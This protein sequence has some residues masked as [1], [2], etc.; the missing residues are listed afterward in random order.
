MSIKRIKIKNVRGIP[1]SSLEINEMLSPNKPIFF[2]APNGFGKTS[3]ATAF[4]SLKTNKLDVPEE[5]KHNNDLN[6]ESV[7]E[8][9]DE[10]KTYVANEKL[11]NINNK[12]KI[13]VINTQVKPK[14][15]TH[16]YG[17][18]PTSTSSLVVEPI[19]LYNVIP[20][21]KKVSYAFSEIK[22]GFN[23]SSSKLVENL[24]QNFKEVKFIN[25]FLGLKKDF[26]KL[27][28]S[29]NSQ[30]L[31]NFIDK[32]NNISDIKEE[33]SKYDLGDKS[34]LAIESFKNVVEKLNEIF[35]TMSFNEKVV[36]VYQ[37]IYVF[38][39]NKESITD[40]TKYYSFMS[41][42]NE[43]S[44][45]LELL[46]CTWKEIKT[47]NRKGKF[48][49]EFPKANQI[50]NG[51]RDILCFVGKLFEAKIKLRKENCILI[52]DEIFDY[53]DDANLI[54]AQYFILKFINQFKKN[55]RNLYPIILTHLD[56]E[57]FKTYN[58]S[59]KNVIYLDKVQQNK[60][61]Y[62][63]NTLLKD[64]ANCKKKDK[65]SYEIISSNYLHYSAN[66]EDDAKQYLSN[67]GIGEELLM[68]EDFRTVASQELENYKEGNKYDLALVCA[69]LRI[70]I[71]KQA[72]QQLKSEERTKFLEKHMTVDKLKFAKENG[73]DIPETHFL[74]SIIY[75]ECMHLDSQCK[76][77]NP[78]AIKLNNKVIK[79]MICEI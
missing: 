73:A 37:L 19:V 25:K 31:N 20:Q 53:L 14:A 48:I 3:I 33:I 76:R 39:N 61:K 69:G 74:L 5:N 43:I 65:K 6:S 59:T 79:K 26:N 27:Q 11:N 45:M 18:F 32:I 70:S 42:K 4:N 28:Q 50:S 17:N 67:L 66:D 72:Y 55:N 1:S 63:I 52:F 16:N 2:V 62:K 30:K 36:N 60:N 7:I 21:T 40:I 46:N 75:N 51:E 10:E 9:E 8:I 68:P 54:S 13:M 64:R 71:E 58:F 12:Y 15:T 34:L 44:E 24:S 49:I 38:E 77:L 47:I 29:R 23:G 57:Y 78:I 41:D 35:S 22:R 56:P